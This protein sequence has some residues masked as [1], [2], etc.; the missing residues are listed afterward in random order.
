MMSIVR[1]QRLPICVII[2]ACLFSLLNIYRIITQDVA[3]IYEGERLEEAMALE[4]ELHSL[5]GKKVDDGNAEVADATEE[6]QYAALGAL[7][8]DENDNIAKYQN[9]PFTIGAVQFELQSDREH[10][11][12]N[13]DFFDIDHAFRSW[14]ESSEHKDIQA[15]RAKAIADDPPTAASGPA[16]RFIERSSVVHANTRIYSMEP[17]ID[18]EASSTNKLPAYDRI[19]VRCIGFPKNGAKLGVIF[20][21]I[22]TTWGQ[23]CDTFAVVTSNL[24]EF[25]QRRRAAIKAA[26]KGVTKPTVD[27]MR[28]ML[29]SLEKRVIP[30][31]LGNSTKWTLPAFTGPDTDANKWQH[32]IV[33]A[34]HLSAWSDDV[35]KFLTTWTSSFSCETVEACMAGV[36]DDSRLLEFVDKTQEQ[37]E[38]LLSG[39]RSSQ[40]EHHNARYATHLHSYI[41][42]ER[43][44]SRQNDAFGFALFFS[45]DTLAF[46]HE[47]R[48]MLYEPQ[49]RFVQA[50]NG[51][52]YLGHAL[53]ANPDQFFAGGG[54]VVLNRAAIKLLVSTIVGE[55]RKYESGLHAGCSLG[56]EIGEA[57]LALTGCFGRAG[58]H[59]MNTDDEFQERRMWLWGPFGVKDQLHS[60]QPYEWYSKYQL[61]DPAHKT[62]EG[63]A[64]TRPVLFGGVE[65]AAMQRCYEAFGG[66]KAL[67]SAS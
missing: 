66:T 49:F 63:F 46:P 51:P 61:R 55:Q 22:L 59:L 32:Y 7:L 34:Q 19:K 36:D 48:R 1:S 6:E 27:A 35:D 24:V 43:D 26:L 10:E 65:A 62:Y 17:G 54:R 45:E 53:L 60:T 12:E 44:S 67:F 9:P 16:E 28:Q 39:H 42:H 18:Q 40:M 8:L 15:Q 41:P 2:V 38:A 33:A 57:H 30:V 52:L 47:L 11:E 58:V 4:D 29:I 37:L 23:E 13:S 20:E 3:V 56:E 50:S 21:T 25:H 31:Y 5:L 64:S 14:A